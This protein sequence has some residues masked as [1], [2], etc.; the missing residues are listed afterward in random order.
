MAE[1]Y[2]RI[3]RCSECGANDW[4]YEGSETATPSVRRM[5]FTCNNCHAQ[6]KALASEHGP[7]LAIFPT[8]KQADM[9]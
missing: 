4:S 8:R 9:R 3:M 2:R 7:E 6:F 5:H 1:E